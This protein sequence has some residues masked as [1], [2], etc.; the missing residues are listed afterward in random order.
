MEYVVQTNVFNAYLRLMEMKKFNVMGLFS[1]LF[2]FFKWDKTDSSGPFTVLLFM[3]TSLCA[4][5]TSVGTICKLHTL[6]RGYW[7]GTMD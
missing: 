3:I 5:N 7:R 6:C 1:F 2:F 4:W